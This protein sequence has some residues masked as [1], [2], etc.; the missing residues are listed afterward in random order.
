MPS[1]GEFDVEVYYTCPGRDVG[2]TIEL[3]FNGQS[4]VGQVTEPHDP[5]LIGAENDRV[6][7]MESYDKYFQSLPLGRIKLK[8]GSGQ[9]TLRALDIPGS[10][11]MDFRLLM[12]TR[13]Q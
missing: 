4:I 10:Q 8:K 7:R 2:S 3:S 5:P 9:L 6:P 13:R 1:N 11:V 12:L